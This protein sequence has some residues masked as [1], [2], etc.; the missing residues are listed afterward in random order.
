[1]LV[2]IGHLFFLDT[3]TYIPLFFVCISSNVHMFDLAFNNVLRLI[4]MEECSN[5]HT[6]LFS[7]AKYDNIN[8]TITIQFANLVLTKTSNCFPSLLSRIK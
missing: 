5:T 3:L 8:D 7:Q 1:M 2:L 4:I 6:Y